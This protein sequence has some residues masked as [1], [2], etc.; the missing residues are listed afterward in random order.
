MHRYTIP[1][2][3]SSATW[4]FRAFKSNSVCDDKGIDVFVYYKLIL[5]D[6]I[7]FDCSKAWVCVCLIV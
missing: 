3:T 2:D 5:S 7:V 6:I 1:E 4:S